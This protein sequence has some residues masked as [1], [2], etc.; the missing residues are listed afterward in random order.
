M[1]PFLDPKSINVSQSLI[2]MTIIATRKFLVFILVFLLCSKLY[3]VSKFLVFILCSKWSKWVTCFVF[4]VG[5]LQYIVD[6]QMMVVIVFDIYNYFIPPVVQH[7]E[8]WI[9][10]L[11]DVCSILSEYWAVPFFIHTRV[12][13]TK[14]LKTNTPWKE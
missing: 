10:N 1:G 8:G 11:F 9:S 2:M 3:Y 4:Y 5:Y 14:F 7:H 12:W 13:T 6:L